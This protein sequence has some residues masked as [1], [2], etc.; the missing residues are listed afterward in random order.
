MKRPILSCSFSQIALLGVGLLTACITAKAQSEPKP[1]PQLVTSK[2]AYPVISKLNEE[3]RL[4]APLFG[5]MKIIDLKA[6]DCFGVLWPDG[7]RLI[8]QSSGHDYGLEFNYSGEPRQT[9]IGLLYVE[10]DVVVGG[11]VLAAGPYFVF[12]SPGVA[13]LF[14]E[15]HEGSTPVSTSVKLGLVT[16]LEAASLERK[17]TNRPRI[18]IRVEGAKA[19]LEI[20]ANRF[21]LRPAE[22]K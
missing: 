1:S 14:T 10:K 13:T 4:V 5:E 12:V 20:G 8:G 17:A 18:G 21:E 22:K 19:H 9:N 3:G 16:A 11:E 2:V 15:K 7:T 6:D